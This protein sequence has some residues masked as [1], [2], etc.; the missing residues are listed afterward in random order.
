MTTKALNF[1]KKVFLGTLYDVQFNSCKRGTGTP[2]SFLE[3]CVKYF[4]LEFDKVWCQSGF[5]VTRYYDIT[6][7]TIF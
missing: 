1:L 2:K 4:D 3:Y 7:V 5:M 6:D